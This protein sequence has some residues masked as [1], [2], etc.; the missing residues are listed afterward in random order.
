[1]WIC[2]YITSYNI[3]VWCSATHLAVFVAHRQHLI[4]CVQSCNVGATT[5]APAH[6]ER[7][8]N[9]LL[10]TITLNDANLVGS[11]ALYQLWYQIHVFCNIYKMYISYITCVQYIYIMIVCIY[12]YHVKTLCKHQTFTLANHQCP[13]HRLGSGNVRTST[14]RLLHLRRV[15]LG[16]PDIR[17]CLSK[18][19]QHCICT[20]LW[21]IL[22]IWPTDFT[23]EREACVFLAKIES[24][25]CEMLWM[26]ILLNLWSL[27]VLLSLNIPWKSIASSWSSTT[28]TSKQPGL[29]PT[30]G[31][32]SNLGYSSSLPPDS[33]ILLGI[34]HTSI[35]IIHITDRLMEAN[36]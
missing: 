16:F 29:S 17:S 35:S 4:I 30:C 27:Q 24:Q 23:S 3:L 1:M 11:R 31:S 7:A 13:E 14:S 25:G 21:C 34:T 33:G 12:Q 19:M 20:I 22:A 5:M 8:S 18:T 28:T 9:T 36:V 26:N 15:G 2:I 32:R 6:L 10:H